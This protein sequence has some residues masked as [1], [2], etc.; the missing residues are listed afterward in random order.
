M[1]VFASISAL[2]LALAA[3][4]PAQEGLPA[5]ISVSAY[6]RYG[7]YGYD[8]IVTIANGC[9]QRAACL[10][11]TDVNP[12]PIGVEVAPETRESVVTF[13]GSPASRFS[14]NV[15]CELRSGS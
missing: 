8:H 5:C 1:K 12:D 2:W 3:A 7:A 4:A 14:A 9:D 11:T 6:A 13:R 15:R 10:V